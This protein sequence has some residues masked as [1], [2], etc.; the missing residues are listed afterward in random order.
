MKMTVRQSFSSFSV[1]F[2]LVMMSV[3]QGCE[4]TRSITEQPTLSFDTLYTGFS[5]K[6]VHSRA[7]DVNELFVAVGGKGGVVNILLPD[8]S[9]RYQIMKKVFGE[10]ED[11]RDLE[12]L[13]VGACILM[14]AGKDGILFGVAPGGGGRVIYDTT[15]V[16]FDGMDFWESNPNYGIVYGDPINGQFFLARTNNM[17]LDWRAITPASLPETLEN[18]AGFAASGSGIQTIGDSTVYF[19]TGNAKVARIFKSS[20]LGNN[21]EVMETPM[22]AGKGFGIYSLHFWSENEGIIIGGSYL[23]STYQKKICFYTSDGGKNWENR[24]EGLG[25]YCSTV[26]SNQEGSLTIASGRMGTYFSE[27]KGLSW[28]LLTNRKFYTSLIKGNSIYFTGK[29][30][31]YAVY[32]YNRPKS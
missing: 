18:E 9:V 28:H 13:P 15:G 30:G 22:K 31:A 7:I 10:V 5:E 16:F 27:N 19:G 11:Y 12:L 4:A 1:G 26:S 32:K 29:N 20:D 25:G 8:T 17:G 21:W 2:V 23:D 14:N 6:G 24:S 3:F